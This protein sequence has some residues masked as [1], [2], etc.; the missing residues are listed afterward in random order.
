MAPDC[1]Y[2]RSL[3]SLLTFTIIRNY[4]NVLLYKPEIGGGEGNL[5]S[6]SLQY[7]LLTSYKSS[8][9]QAHDVTVWNIYLLVK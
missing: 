5:N 1:I 2:S 6:E 3:A 4:D 7:V 8:G 9:L